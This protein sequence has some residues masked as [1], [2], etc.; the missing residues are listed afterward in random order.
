MDLDLEPEYDISMDVPVAD[1]QE[2][3]EIVMIM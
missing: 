3:S 2:Q 1:E